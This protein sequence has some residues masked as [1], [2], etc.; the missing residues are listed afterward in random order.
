MTDFFFTCACF[1]D[2]DSLLVLAGCMVGGGLVAAIQVWLYVLLDMNYLFILM[3][4]LTGEA[5]FYFFD[6]TRYFLWISEQ[7]G[8]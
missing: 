1:F 2:D 6:E 8:F 7:T 3:L 4:F 5:F